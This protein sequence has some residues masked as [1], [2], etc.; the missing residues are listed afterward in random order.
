MQFHTVE[1]FLYQISLLDRYNES[2][3]GITRPNSWSPWRLETLCAGLLT[4]KLFLDSYLSHPLREEMAFNNT[5]WVQLG[6]AL[7][8]ATKF[9]VAGTAKFISRETMNP[10]R[11]L[12]ISSMLQRCV[13]RTRALISPHLDDD[14]ERDVFY[15]YEKR[16]RALQC[17]FEKQ[18][19]EQPVLPPFG[20]NQASENTSLAIGQYPKTHITG[21]DA[22]DDFTDFSGFDKDRL[23]D[24]AYDSNIPNRFTEDTLDGIMGDWMSYPMFPVS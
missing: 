10:R 17:W 13:L 14:G 4:S 6:F 23:A 5:E 19:L 3:K 15:H 7:I 21:N 20:N 8:V 22:L 2:D 16:A 24:E 1:M 12:D 9:P 11:S 18:S